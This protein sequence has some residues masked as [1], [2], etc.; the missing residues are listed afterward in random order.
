MSEAYESD[1]ESSSS[2]SPSTIRKETV[3][4]ERLDED[5]DDEEQEEE[6]VLDWDSVVA[7]L[8]LSINDRS[9]KKRTV[10]IHRYLTV[11][12]TCEY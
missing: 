12:E 6:E 11:S 3:V 8:R 1:S 7:K 10:F 4:N 5:S 9:T 2:V